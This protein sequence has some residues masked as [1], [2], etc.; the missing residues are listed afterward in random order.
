MK[1]DLRDKL[2]RVLLIHASE[3]FAVPPVESE[4]CPEHADHHRM[5]GFY[6]DA[7]SKDEQRAIVSAYN[8]WYGGK[9][10]G[11]PSELEDNGEVSSY[12]IFEF[13]ASLVK[14]GQQNEGK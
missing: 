8:E 12:T 14:R 1:T 4:V 7:F 10:V 2:L 13:A 9:E 6:G 5:W 11:I 3:H